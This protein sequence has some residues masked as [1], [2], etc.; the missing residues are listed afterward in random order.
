[1]MMIRMMN[2]IATIHRGK[3]N[4]MRIQQIGASKTKQNARSTS[5][6]EP[7]KRKSGKKFFGFMDGFAKRY[8][9]RYC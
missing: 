9:R 2:D 6:S 7:K 4:F 5:Q 8:R 3:L 1:M